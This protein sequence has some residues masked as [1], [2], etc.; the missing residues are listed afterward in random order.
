MIRNLRFFCQRV[1]PVV[2]DDSL[3]YIELLYKVINKINETVIEI[4]KLEDY[5]TSEDFTREV[6]Q[7]VDEWLENHP[8]ATT[9]VLD[10]SLTLIKL[11]ESLKA[12]VEAGINFNDSSYDYPNYI[13]NTATLCG[14]DKQAFAGNG[15]CYNPDEDIYVW[16]FADNTDNNNPGIF[17]TTDS[18]FNVLGRY[19][20]NFYHA[21]S[22]DYIPDTK[23]YIVAT[24]DTAASSTGMVEIFDE[25]FSLVSQ[26]NLTGIDGVIIS[27][28]AYDQVHD[29]Y[30]VTDNVR[31]IY[32]YDRDFNKISDLGSENLDNPYSRYG[33]YDYYYQQGCTCY[34]GYFITQAWLRKYTSSNW[35]GF[36]AVNKLS[37]YDIN[38]N[39]ITNIYTESKNGFDECEDIT[40]VGD[41]LRS[42]SYF[43]SDPEVQ[44]NDIYITDIYTK[45]NF[46]PVNRAAKNYPSE[47]IYGL[48]GNFRMEARGDV[49]SF[50]TGGFI[51]LP[52]NTD[53]LIGTVESIF[54]PMQNTSVIITGSSGDLVRLLIKTNGEIFAFNYSSNTETI[55]APIVFTYMRMEPYGPYID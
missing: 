48:N 40:T 47:N 46:K 44:Y 15:F 51:N 9:T 30:F 45:S 23:Q 55:N 12:I 20:A 10:N 54:R 41:M 29:L 3:S 8:E 49:A 11:H 37:V 50:R 26:H 6:K 17:I 1:L 34:K 32:T 43:R 35:L 14:E 33:N 21:N 4:N 25:G 31:K 16:A 22:L 53:T 28:I 13:T 36:I 52:T 24:G 42:W 18:D 5:I 19:Q 38:G 7:Y 39:N 2:Y 27:R